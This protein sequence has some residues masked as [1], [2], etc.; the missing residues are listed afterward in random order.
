VPPTSTHLKTDLETRV[1]SSPQFDE[2][3]ENI[4]EFSRA[5][6]K[7]ALLMKAPDSYES[8]YKGNEIGRDRRGIGGGGKGEGGR[9][10]E[11]QNIGL[12]LEGHVLSS[13]CPFH[14]R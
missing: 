1:L 10:K 5:G 12:N 14:I 4:L 7:Q 2:V 9:R 11:G 8:V 6:R 3:Y 13:I